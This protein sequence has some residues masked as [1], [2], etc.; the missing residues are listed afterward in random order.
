MGLGCLPA[1]AI[2]LVTRGVVMATETPFFLRLCNPAVCSLKKQCTRNCR[3]LEKLGCSQEVRICCSRSLCL[4]CA[5]PK[6]GHQ[7]YRL[8]AMMKGTEFRSN[9][10]SP[11]RDSLSMDASPESFVQWFPQS[12]GAARI[13]RASASGG[14]RCGLCV[15]L[16]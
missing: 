6:H 3:A 1:G 2:E 13:I 5:L 14:T 12:R 15:L 10:K 7:N 16:Y 11:P 4:R 8:I 9:R